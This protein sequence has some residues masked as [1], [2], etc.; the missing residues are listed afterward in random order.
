MSFY[1]CIN[2][3]DWNY[4]FMLRN[5]TFLKRRA[6]KCE[7]IFPSCF[8]LFCLCIFAVVSL[9]SVSSFSFSMA[10]HVVVASFRAARPRLLSRR[11]FHVN[12]RTYGPFCFS[13]SLLPS[14]R[15][16]RFLLPSSRG[17][18]PRLAQLPLASGTTTFYRGTL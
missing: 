4:V 15:G 9:F 10:V 18:L 1:F 17:F 16:S 14:L 7:K 3:S 13:F 11:I 12:C 6:G 2:I 8:F 5:T